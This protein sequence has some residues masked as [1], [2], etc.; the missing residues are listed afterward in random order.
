MTMTE[1]LSW[2]VE[3]FD[4]L[5]LDRLYAILAARVAVFVVEQDCPY[6][7]LD[8]LDGCGLHIG[9]WSGETVLAYARLLPPGKR[10]AEPSIGRVLTTQAARGTGLGRELMRRSIEAAGQCFPDKPLRISAQQYLE[11]FYGELGFE[12]VSEPYPEDG[13]AH[14][15][16]FRPWRSEK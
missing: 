15:E 6:Q 10:F 3:R 11:R 9:A 13:I 16:M 14:V 2:R 8:G 7:D 4:E 5:S 1:Q 12:T